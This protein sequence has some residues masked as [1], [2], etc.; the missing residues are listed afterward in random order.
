MIKSKFVFAVSFVALFACGIAHADI[1]SVSY[2]NGKQLTAGDN[3][4]I[5]NGTISVP[6]CDNDGTEGITCPDNTDMPASTAMVM[7]A[8]ARVLPDEFFYDG[9]EDFE[10]WESEEGYRGGNIYYNVE[11][12]MNSVDGL[13]AEL[14]DKQPRING[15]EYCYEDE[16]GI[17]ICEEEGDFV[18]NGIVTADKDGEVKVV[19][20]S[21]S[22]TGKFIT[23]VTVADNGTV[24]LTRGDATIN[25]AGSENTP[26]FTK[27]GMAQAV[28]SIAES[29]LPDATKANKG[30]VK[31]DDELSA[32]ST[33]PVQNK[34]VNAALDNK[35]DKIDVSGLNVG[36]EEYKWTFVTVD[37]GGNVVAG[38]TK[39]EG[40]GEFVTGIAAQPDG[41]VKIS[42]GGVKDATATVKGIA[43]LGTIPAG[44]NKTGTATIWIE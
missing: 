17:Q 2:V 13:G 36:E 20:I 33:N 19:E 6:V 15:S 14:A 32:T 30:A 8:F 10:Y 24:T 43:T 9:P 26:V 11:N 3:V 34:V 12:L 35:Q 25:N 7:R 40:T 38:E 28:T 16:D 1:A 21:D 37:D 27:D 22:G 39:I 44:A 5:D 18:T 29:L 41:G 31:V 42:K 23:D 4:Q